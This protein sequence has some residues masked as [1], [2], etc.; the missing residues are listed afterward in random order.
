MYSDTKQI[1]KIRKEI[2]ARKN[3]SEAQKSE[4]ILLFRRL[5][6]RFRLNP[7]PIPLSASVNE[8]TQRHH[9]INAQISYKFQIAESLI[10]IMELYPEYIPLNKLSRHDSVEEII[11]KFSFDDLSKEIENFR[12]QRL[13]Q[14][15]V[16][17]IANN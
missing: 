14:N 8:I 12:A 13:E 3:L 7:L 5:E 9:E 17:P 11:D 4:S 10:A 6:K 15:M 1:E 16:E 2:D